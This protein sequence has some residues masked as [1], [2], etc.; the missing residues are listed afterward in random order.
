MAAATTG[1]TVTSGSWNGG[2]GATDGDQCLV[3]LQL[4]VLA[5]V[6][7]LQKQLRVGREEGVRRILGS[8]DGD[9]VMKP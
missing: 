1:A 5:I 7:L 9:G 2:M 8:D 6:L 3:L 4:V